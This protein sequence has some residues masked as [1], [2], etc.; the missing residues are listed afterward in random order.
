MKLNLCSSSTR[1]LKNT[2]PDLNIRTHAQIFQHFLTLSYQGNTKTRTQTD[3]QKEHKHKNKPSNRSFLSTK[4]KNNKHKP[5]H[6]QEYKYKPNNPSSANPENI[7]ANT[8]T[9]HKPKSDP[10]HPSYLAKAFNLWSLGLLEI[11]NRGL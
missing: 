2:N 5:K 7:N 8:A 6:Q 4:H 1:R 3:F 11:Q 10:T 9:K